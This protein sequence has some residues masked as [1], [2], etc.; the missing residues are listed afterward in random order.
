MQPVV[1]FPLLCLNGGFGVL[2]A[3]NDFCGP[4]FG[5][6][7]LSYVEG[8]QECAEVIAVTG[9]ADAERIFNRR[10]QRILESL[11]LCATYAAIF[12]F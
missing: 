8:L 3:G 4:V 1:G 11:Y 5:Q 6:G 12:D 7:L 2:V 10:F 9:D